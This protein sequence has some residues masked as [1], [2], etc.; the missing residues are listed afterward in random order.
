VA[1]F[2]PMQAQVFAYI[3]GKTYMYNDFLRKPASAQKFHKTLHTLFM[4]PPT[5]QKNLVS[6]I[7]RGLRQPKPY[8]HSISKA[9]N[10]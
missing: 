9:K 1:N 10:P 8:F 3:N 7:N 2:V 6:I 4:T 5:S